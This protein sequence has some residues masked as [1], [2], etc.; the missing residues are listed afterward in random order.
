[1][2]ALK[3]VC[4]G[5]ENQG[6]CAMCGGELG[7]RRRVYCSGEC[8]E[9][10]LDLF[11]WPYARYEAIE[12]AHHRCQECGVTKRGLAKIYARWFEKA[13]LEVHHIIPLNGEFR[14]W[15][16]LNI[17]SNLKV[18]CHD[19]HVV[20]RKKDIPAVPSKQT[21]QLRLIYG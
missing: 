21:P 7:K 4:T 1:M 9:L 14:Q 2:A 20:T 13:Q 18:L 15:H 11:F 5:Y 8:A 3:V 17:P 16:P 12:R 6:I 19:C 10:Y